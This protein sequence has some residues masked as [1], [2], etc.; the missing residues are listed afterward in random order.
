[1]V[2]KISSKLCLSWLQTQ[3][4]VHEDVGSVLVSGLRILLR[5]GQKMW[6]RSTVAL[7]VA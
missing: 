4:N 1:M 2:F 3:H 6:L 5:L 7:A